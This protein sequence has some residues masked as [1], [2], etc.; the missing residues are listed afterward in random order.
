MQEVIEPTTT[1][2][3]LQAQAVIT[4]RLQN[5][6]LLASV[7]MRASDATK[8][9]T[10]LESQ[11]FLETCRRAGCDAN[12]MAGKFHKLIDEGNRNNVQFAIKNYC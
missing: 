5:L 4:E 6:S 10:W 1:A 8:I 9:L 3:R 2:E 11:E 12:V 7:G